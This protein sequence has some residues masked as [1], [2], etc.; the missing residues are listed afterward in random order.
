MGLLPETFFELSWADFFR[1]NYNYKLKQQQDWEKVRFIST[2]LVNINVEKKHQIKPQQ[3]FK[4]NIIDKDYLSEE[5]LKQEII[6]GK[7]KDGFVIDKEKEQKLIQFL[8]SLPPR[9]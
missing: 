5:E 6:D 1:M 9:P 7:R 3:L 4:L 8:N 2:I